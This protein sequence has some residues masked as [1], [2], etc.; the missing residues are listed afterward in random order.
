MKKL[1]VINAASNKEESNTYHV[2]KDVMSKINT[3]AY[4]VKQLDL[5]NM[6]LPYLNPE[7][8][9]GKMTKTFNTD[10]E[11]NIECLSEEFCN[12]DAFVFVFPTWNLGIPAIM[13]SYLDAVVDAG[14]TFK[15]T[16]NGPVGLMD[17]KKAI[18]INTC[19]GE[20]RHAMQYMCDLS[21]FIAL[22]ATEILVTGSA[23]KYANKDEMTKTYQINPEHLN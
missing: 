22:D 10:V 8:L 14:K 5:I 1:L 21:E 18:L 13:K 2:Y 15:Y 9:N 3:D 16:E 19:G 4:E 23:Y 12:S 7:I 20:G 6:E 11:K 17:N